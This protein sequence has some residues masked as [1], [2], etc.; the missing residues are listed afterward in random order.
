MAG[1]IRNILVC[2]VKEGTP[3][4][5]QVERAV[6]ERIVSEHKLQMA[7]GAKVRTMYGPSLPD[8]NDPSAV[9]GTVMGLLR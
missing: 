3:A 2:S 7:E 5:A 9:Q 6:M 1:M 4:F 8:R